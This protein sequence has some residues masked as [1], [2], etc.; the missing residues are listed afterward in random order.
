MTRAEKWARYRAIRDTLYSSCWDCE[1][2][3]DECCLWARE[4]AFGRTPTGWLAETCAE[5]Y[6]LSTEGPGPGELA[7]VINVSVSEA[8]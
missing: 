2:P 7:I 4:T 1:R 3:C 5:V 6:R 8:E